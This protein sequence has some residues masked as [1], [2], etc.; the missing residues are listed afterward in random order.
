[1]LRLGG[2]LAEGIEIVLGQTTL[3]ES[4]GVHAGGGVAL[5]EDLVA[6][7]GVILAAEEVVQAH[8]V[9]RSRA[10]VGGDVA[11]HADAGALRAV[12]HDGGVPPDPAAVALFDFLVTGELGFLGGGNGV[13]IVRGQQRRQGNALGGGALQQ[14]E[15]EVASAVRSCCLQQSI[16]RFHP[17]LSFLGVGILEVRSDTVPDK[18][19]V[20]VAGVARIISHDQGLLGA[21][22][23]LT[24][25]HELVVWRKVCVESTLR[26]FHP[27]R[28]KYGRE[29]EHET[30]LS[31]WSARAVQGP[32]RGHA[33][34]M[35]IQSRC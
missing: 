32:C 12:H 3:Q 28:R 14:A 4:A 31:H 20:A 15:H 35:Q 13:D 11:A 24:L 19:E 16:E 5:E 7:T 2:L 25:R 21:R 8:F 33:G 30:N 6:A 18:G 9:E 26:K 17:F 10:R 34:A 1:M 27:G 23:V 29:T 22:A